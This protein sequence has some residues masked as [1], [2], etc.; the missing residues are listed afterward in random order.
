METRD[1][2]P[3]DT[4]PTERH[5]FSV[6]SDLASMPVSDAELDV[7]EAFLMHQF[8]AV[9]TEGSATTGLLLSKDSEAPQTHAQ[10]RASALGQNKRPSMG[11]K[12]GRGN[13][14]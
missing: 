1:Q 4:A 7:I 3:V 9:M 11:G 13:A 14:R 8:R 2:N 5:G 6:S 10:V 12:R